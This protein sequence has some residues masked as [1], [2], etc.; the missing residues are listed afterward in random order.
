MTRFPFIKVNQNDEFFYMTKMK[1]SFLKDCVDFHFRTNLNNEKDIDIEKYF[2]IWDKARKEIES[3]YKKKITLEIEP[4]RLLVSDSGYLVT[5][6]RAL[7]KMGS[8]NFVITNS[9]FNDLMRPAMYGSSHKI[10]LIK[11][12]DTKEQTIQSSII[13]GSLCESGDVFTQDSLGIPQKVSIPTPQVEDLIV[14]HNCGAY[15]ASMSS[16][17]NARL[18]AAEVLVDGKNYHLIRSRETLSQ[19]LENEEPYL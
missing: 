6:I 3:F 8:N 9:G 19:L 5:E 4:G 18:R 17:Y 13:A 11:N 1:V 2:S 12:K 10:S 16:N 15:G 7:K 14:I